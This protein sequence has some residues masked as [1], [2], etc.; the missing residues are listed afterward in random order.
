VAS[1]E[2]NANLLRVETNSAGRDARAHAWLSELLGDAVESVEVDSKSLEQARREP[3]PAVAQARALPRK[4]KAKLERELLDRHYR[5]WLDVPVPALDNVTPRQA[6]RDPKLRAR[7]IDL[8]KG[9]ENHSARGAGA[10]GPAY[11]P[12][13]CG[14]R[15]GWVRSG[16]ESAE[17]FARMGS[18]I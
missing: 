11:D 6:A 15:L 16:S 9:L 18:I 13:G 7:L 12:A 14:R 4:L 1:L 5:E 10:S 8:L 3:A 17:S 2:L